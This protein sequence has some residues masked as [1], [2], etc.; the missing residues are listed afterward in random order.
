MACIIAPAVEAIAVSIAS[1]KI[2]SHEETNGANMKIPFS[3]KVK[4]LSNLLWGGSALLAFEHIWHGEIVP[5]FPF[6]TGAMNPADTAAMLQEIATTGI[7]MAAI[8]TAVWSGMLVVA[9]MAEKSI[10][11]EQINVKAR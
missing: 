4:W 7:T 2:K 3:R 6:L 1:K 9:H 5:Y 10:Q 8:I 11:K